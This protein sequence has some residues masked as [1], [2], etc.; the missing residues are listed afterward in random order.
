[1]ATASKRARV[2]RWGASLETSTESGDVPHVVG[3]VEI[4]RGSNSNII[5]E[6]DVDMENKTDGIDE[7]EGDIEGDIGSIFND[8]FTKYDEKISKK[9]PELSEGNPEKVPEKGSE[10]VSEDGVEIKENSY[11]NVVE[12]EVRSDRLRIVCDDEGNVI[13]SDGDIVFRTIPEAIPEP[14]IIKSTGNNHVSVMG[15]A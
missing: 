12:S 3:S 14:E 8:F 11:V 13:G 5:E 4:A 9:D 15:M 2:S 10:E 1:V 6:D 7:K